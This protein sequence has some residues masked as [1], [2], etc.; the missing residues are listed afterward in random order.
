MMTEKHI[1]AGIEILDSLHAELEIFTNQG[2]EFY[3][4]LFNRIGY[5]IAVLKGEVILD[6]KA[7]DAPDDDMPAGWRRVGPYTLRPVNSSR[8]GRIIMIDGSGPDGSAAIGFRTVAECEAWIT[9]QG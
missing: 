5:I 7:T 8:F 4:D 2:E 6:P 1:K 9:K 3:D